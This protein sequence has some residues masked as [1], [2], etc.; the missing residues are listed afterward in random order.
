MLRNVLLRSLIE[1]TPLHVCCQY[2]IARLLY[3]YAR[4][5]FTH[6]RPFMLYF[7]FHLESINDDVPIIRAHRRFLLN[8]LAVKTSQLAYPVLLCSF[9]LHNLP[10][11]DLD[12]HL[13]ILHA[14][15]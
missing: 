14:A 9:D 12:S 7:I 2:I 11:L 3:K 1:Y 8:S 15:D 10:G 4:P 5:Y 6:K 13:P